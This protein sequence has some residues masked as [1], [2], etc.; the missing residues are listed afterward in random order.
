MLSLLGFPLFAGFIGKFLILKAIAIDGLFSI[1][2]IILISSLLEAVYYFK[3]IGFMFIKDKTDEVLE[4]P[5]IH[6][7]VFTILALLLLFIGIFPFSI[8]NFLLDCADVFLDFGSFVN[9][10]VENHKG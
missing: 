8:S 9:I 5:I 6:K 2:A 4:V 1:I 10:L 3:L 7:I